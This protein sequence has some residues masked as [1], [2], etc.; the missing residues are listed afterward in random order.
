M[1]KDL[2]RV[3][4]QAASRGIPAFGATADASEAHRLTLVDELDWPKLGCQLEPGGTVYLNKRGT[5][6][7]SSASYWWGR[8]GAALTRAVFYTLGSGAKVYI[9]LLAGD[10]FFLVLGVTLVEASCGAS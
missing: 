6:G 9:F 2:K 4:R 7:I 8:V 1:A 3:L 10:W 5:Y